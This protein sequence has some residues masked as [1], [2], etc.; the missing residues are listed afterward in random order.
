VQWAK[1]ERKAIE[2]KKGDGMMKQPENWRHE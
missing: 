2:E 1:E